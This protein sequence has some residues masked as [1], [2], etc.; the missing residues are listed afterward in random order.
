MRLQEIF[1]QLVYGELAQFSVNLGTSVHGAVSPD[2][3]PKVVASVRMAVMEM[4]KEFRLSIEVVDV[5][6]IS[7]VTMY[8]LH[9]D[10]SIRNTDTSIPYKYIYDT[11]NEPFEDNLLVIDR[12]FDEVGDELNLNNDQA[13][14]SLYTP[15]FNTLQIPDPIEGSIVRV[16][17]AKGHSY[18][19][20]A[21]TIDPTTIEIEIPESC[22]EPLLFYIAGRMLMGAG[23]LNGTNDANIMMAK[24]QQSKLRI[25]E[26]GL[27]QQDNTFNLKLERNG[28]A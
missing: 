28:W 14:F 10:Y 12:V 5:M 24:Y 4:Y 25:K 16:L 23:N 19:S 11:A 17:I 2:N 13:K 7:N 8:K 21:T 15:K 26:L 6:M 22:L 3:Y 9:S 20:G 27:Y 18:I 1:D